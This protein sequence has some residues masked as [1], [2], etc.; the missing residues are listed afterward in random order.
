M[1]IN[2]MSLEAIM[3]YIEGVLD[4]EHMHFIHEMTNFDKLEITVITHNCQF[5]MSLVTVYNDDKEHKFVLF[6]IR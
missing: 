1:C 3:T 2:M 6:L 5:N 4:C